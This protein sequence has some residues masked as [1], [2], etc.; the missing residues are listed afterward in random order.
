ML[1][2]QIEAYGSPY[3]TFVPLKIQDVY[4]DRIPGRLSEMR[5]EDTWSTAGSG[6]QAA[7]IGRAGL[8]VDLG[9]AGTCSWSSYLICCSTLTLPRLVYAGHRYPHRQGHRSCFGIRIHIDHTSRDPNG[10]HVHLAIL[11]S[12]SSTPNS[13][14]N[15]PSDD[16]LQLA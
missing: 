7:E 10:T 2:E 16:S 15:P 8:R 12:S 6:V 11:V 3:I 13:A 1:K 14:S 9:R 4:D 5:R